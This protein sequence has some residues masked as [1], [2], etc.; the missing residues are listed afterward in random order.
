MT[1]RQ[2]IKDLVHKN[3]RVFINNSDVV[4]LHP[5]DLIRIGTGDGTHFFSILDIEEI[6]H[7]ASIPDTVMER[8]VIQVNFSTVD[9]TVFMDCYV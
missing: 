7:M 4:N 2:V 9:K 3:Y 6:K 8:N 5:L 1:V